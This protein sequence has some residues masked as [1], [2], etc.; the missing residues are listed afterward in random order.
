MS[1]FWF[2]CLC[3]SCL[4][5]FVVCCLIYFSKVWWLFEHEV[6]NCDN[7][8]IRFETFNGSLTKLRSPAVDSDFFHSIPN[9]D[10]VFN[11]DPMDFIEIHLVHSA[12][13]SKTWPR[14]FQLLTLPMPHAMLRSKLQ[15]LLHNLVHLLKKVVALNS[16][17]SIFEK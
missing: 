6:W 2:Y 13:V 7:Y 10:Q 1:L 9:Q 15:L 4:P 17:F 14:V 3:G 5:W 8:K 12:S 11:T 16:Y